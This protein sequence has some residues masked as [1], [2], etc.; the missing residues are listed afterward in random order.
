M[1]ITRFFKRCGL[2]CVHTGGTRRIWAA[3]QLRA[4]N[5]PIGHSADLPSHDLIR[6]L[7]ELLDAEDFEKQTKDREAALAVLNN[8]LKRDGLTVFFD[9]GEAHVRSNGSGASS[10]NLKKLS[11]PL[12]GEELLQREQVS[13]FLDSASEDEFIEELLVPLFQ[14]LGF[15]R[16]SAPGHKE[17]ALEFGK[18]LWMKFQ[19]PTNHWLYFCAQVKK[20]KLDAKGSSGSTN[21][22]TVLNQIR[23][24]VEHPIFDPD[25]GRKV[26]V[27]HVFVISAGEITRAAQAWLIA[28]MDNSQRRQIIFMDRSEFL[29]HSARILIDLRIKTRSLDTTPDIRF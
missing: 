24:A 6:V 3:D 15:H 19:L 9:Q 13:N 21:A 14:R 2:D 10:A 27:D 23:M 12:S 1:F 17:K 11:R 4:L 20:D 18:D 16:V 29:D 5:Q 25:I 8:T 26:L 7:V 28:Q 22:A